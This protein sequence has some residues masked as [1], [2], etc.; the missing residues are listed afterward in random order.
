MT[1]KA[2]VSHRKGLSGRWLVGGVAVIVL[3]VVAALYLSGTFSRSST[4]GASA[5]DTTPVT[6]GNLVATVSGSGSVAA[7]Q[8]LNLSFQASGAVSEVLVEE[9]DVVK[10]G[11]ALARLDDRNL[12]L[13]LESARSSLDSARARLVQAEKGNATAAELAAAQASVRSAQANYDKLAA[14]GSPAEVASAQAAV[15]S[16]QSAY[17]AATAAAGTRDSQLAS[18]AA[19]LEKAT[20]VLQQKQAAYDRVAHMPN[21]GMMSQS[22][23]LQQATIEYEQAKANYDSL[24]RT[25]GVDAQSKVDSAAAQLA[26][27]RATLAKLT[28]SAGDLAAAQASLESAKANLAKL[29]GAATETELTIQQ[30]AVAQAEQS[31]R[32]AE[33]SLANAELKAPFDG[34]VSQ[35]NIVPGS[36]ASMGASAL[37]LIN[38]S[39]LHVDLKLSENDVARVQ[40]GQAVQ[41]TIQSLGGRGIDGQVTYVAPAAENSNGVV[42]YAVRVSF[43]DADPAVKVGMTA[44]LSIVTAQKDNVLLV[45]STA[46]LPKGAGHV[47]KVQG[48]DAQGRAV[49]EER[50]VQIGQS[51]GANTEILSGLQAGERVVTLPT[52]GAAPSRSGFG[53]FGG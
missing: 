33:L 22:V 36:V 27:A 2:G 23:E 3:T 46:L 17:A 40:T 25:T 30:A 31:V 37:T 8:T 10:A 39:P 50:D 52:S 28:P 5:T 51:D 14:G 24:S 18:A 16:A 41:L 35:V 6:L 44:D 4:S 1:S 32:Q 15:R 48:T 9:G 47:V 13:Q 21:I 7:K 43:P 12:Q 19:T 53:P 45:P 34:I 26:S 42:T 38:R 29:T 49:T 11:Q 20:V